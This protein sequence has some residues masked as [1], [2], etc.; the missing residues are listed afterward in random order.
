MIAIEIDFMNTTKRQPSARK[1]SA[2]SPG[3]ATLKTVH[4]EFSDAVA[5]SVAIAGTFN[6]WRPDATPMERVESGRWIKQLNLP[7]GTYEYC[8]VLN[9]AQWMPDPRTPE[10]KPNPFGGCN[11]VLKIPDASQA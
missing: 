7:P 9:G 1:R 6:D 3:R 5:E 2:S 11:S 10:R 8:L 4:I